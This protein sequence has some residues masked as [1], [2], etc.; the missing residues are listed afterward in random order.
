MIGYVRIYKALCTLRKNI[1]VA[2]T[3]THTYTH[4]YIWTKHHNT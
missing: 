1:L 4:V 3:L 2:T